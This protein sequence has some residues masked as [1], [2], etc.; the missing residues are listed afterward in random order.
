[1][2]MG[3]G[4]LLR[5]VERA[6]LPDLQRWWNDAELCRVLGTRRHLTALEETEAWYEEMT[7]RVDPHS[8]RTYAIVDGQGR[9]LGTIWYGPFDPQDRNAEVGLYIGNEADRGRGRGTAALGLL[10]SYLFDDLAVHKVRL[11]VEASNHRA[12]RVYVK[13]GF[14]QEGVLREHRFYAGS[15]HDFVAMG[16]MA[17]ERRA[18]VATSERADRS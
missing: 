3:E 1:M 14:L 5:P 4:I 18:R 11:I 15:H 6:D 7:G 17:G 2:L 9:L 16:L 8:G 13:L 10:L 12:I